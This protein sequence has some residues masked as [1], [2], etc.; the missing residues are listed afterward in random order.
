MATIPVKDGDEQIAYQGKIVE[1]VKQPMKIGDKS[2]QF[3]FA[4]RSPGTRLIIID[5]D[6]QQLLPTK[7]YRHEIDD[8]DYRLP[9]GKVF[10]SLDEYNQF[11]ASGKDMINPATARAKIEAKEEA[12][13]IAKEPKH[14]YTSINGATVVWDLLYFVIDDW[15]ESDQELEDGEDISVEWVGFDTARDYAL[16]NMSEDRSV[17]VLLRWLTQQEA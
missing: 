10:D 5:R 15:E 2:V 16:K 1:V 13:I 11:L 4:R 7:E 14:F 6:K 12:G 17:A 8:Y 3:E 9:G